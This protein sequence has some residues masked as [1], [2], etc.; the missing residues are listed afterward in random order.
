[1]LTPDLPALIARLPDE[2]RAR[3]ERI[4]RVE[5]VEGHLHVPE[6]MR[7]WTM[8]RFGS[9][10]DVEHQQ[11]VRVTNKVTWEGAIFNPLRARRPLRFR[12][13]HGHHAHT[14]A[15]LFANPLT[16]TTEDVY[17]RINGEYCV[18]T[19]NIARWDAQC[20]V[21][22]FA[23]PDPLAFT[24]AHLRDYFR[25]TLKWAEAAHRVDPEARF[26]A[27][28]WNGGSAGGASIPHAHAQMGLGRSTPYA[29]VEGLQRAALAYRAQYKHD[30]FVDLAAAHVDVGLGFKS[31]G[32]DAFLS[33]TPTRMKD[34]W[35][36]GR[37]FDD[38]LADALF[39]VLR[40]LVDRVGMR[41]FDVGV[42]IPPLYTLPGDDWTDFPF[43]ARIVD[44]G[45]PDALSSDIGAMDF[46]GARII[47]DDPFTTRALLP[48]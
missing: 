20:S 25:T 10:S 7:E 24:R 18:T 15:D 26:L 3:F 9:I 21:L 8:K 35:I 43:I 48:F 11:I 42:V 33:L 27:W 13:D 17:G 19:S 32:L 46:F 4:F 38:Q 31:A 23:E 12:E 14:E 1:M 22:V 29:M 28:M 6:A 34:T 37:A 45:R 44:R 2:A 41:G 36:I 39:E 47:A 30:Y 40:A 5:L 16:M